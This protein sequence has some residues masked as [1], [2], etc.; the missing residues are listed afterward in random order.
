MASA[1]A[2][3]VPAR[4]GLAALAV[5][6]LLALAPFEPRAPLLRVWGTGLSLL[7]LL[8]AA[9]VVVLL[10]AGWDQLSALRRRP[11]LPLVCLGA[12]ALAHLLSAAAATS[13]RDLAARFALRMAGMAAVAAAV[14]LAPPEAGRRGLQAL[15]AAGALVAA[16]AVAEI[17]GVW[18]LDPWLDRFRDSL[19]VVGAERRATAG[20]AHPNLAGAFLAYALVAGAAVLSER[21]RAL[22]RVLPFAAL[23]AAGMLATYSRGA[24]AAAAVGLLA[25]A[26]AGGARRRRGAWASLAVLAIAVAAGLTAP[27]FRLRAGGEGTARWFAVRTTPEEPHLALRPGEGRE[28]AV[29]VENTGRVPWQAGRGFMAAYRIRDLATGAW[30]GHGFSPWLD[31]DV[32][33]GQRRR[34]TVRLQAPPRPGRYVVAW[35]M[36]HHHAGWFFEHGSPPAWVSLDVTP[37]GAPLPPPAGPPGTLVAQAEP[38]PTRAELWGAAL[39]LWRDH[40]LLGAGPDNF[41]RLYG[42]RLGRPADPRTYANNTLLEAGAT[43]GLLGA[44]ALLATLA[45][46][47]VRA[48]RTDAALFALAAV[49]AAHGLVDYVLAFT[50]HALVLAFVVGGLSRPHLPTRASS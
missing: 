32:A 46:V 50:G 31:Q 16:L 48:A 42:E 28:T 25:L 6:A 18:A 44:L 21:P 33:P 3:P 39:A 40:P 34:V 11:P 14:A 1:P 15:A 43:T 23:V 27:A 22:R 9:A 37:D 26:L 36:V 8:A 13:H 38:P 45:V 17:A 49:I 10:A 19:V 5:A 29:V 30:A 7:E 35:D 20:S 41:R 47:L 4:H 24:I 12:Y 2:T